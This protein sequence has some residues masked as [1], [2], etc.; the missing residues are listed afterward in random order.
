MK[1]FTWLFLLLSFSLSLFAQSAKNLSLVA[2]VPFPVDLNDVWAYVDGN[3]NEYA[4][5]G[6]VDGVS[7]FDLTDPSTPVEV[8]SIPGTLSVWRDL[9]IFQD[10]AYVSNDDA[11]GLLI[12][13]LSTLP[14]AVNYKDT[15][16]DGIDHAHNIY[17]EDGHLY[18]VGVGNSAMPTGFNGGMVIYDLRNDPWDPQF[19]GAYTDRYVHDVYVRGNR[20]YNGEIDDG[21]LTILD[22]TNKAN[23]SVLGFTDYPDSYTHNTWLNDAG[24]VCFTTDELKEAYVYAWDVTDPTSITLLDGIRSSLSEGLATPH[25]VHV[26]N[27]FLITSYYKDGIQLVD[28]TR[29]T[30]LVEVGHYDTSPMEGGGTDGCWGAYPFLPSGLVLA[31]DIQEGFFVLQPTYI[32]AA[33][34]EG[35]VTDLSNSAP[36]VNVLIEA[37]KP[38]L[39]DKT[40]NMGNYAVGTVDAGTYDIRYA[41]YGYMPENRTVSLSSG[42][43]TIEDVELQPSTPIDLT[44]KV[45]DA[46]TEDPIPFAQLV[47]IAPN[48]EASFPFLTDANGEATDSDFLTGLYEVIAGKWGHVTDGKEVVV[49]QANKTITI[50]LNAGYYDDFIFDN[51]WIKSGTANEGQWERGEP[52][53]TSF[54]GNVINPESDIEGDFGTYAYVTGNSGTGIGD[55]DV[56]GGTA[57]LTSP[58]MDLSNYEDPVLTFEWWLFNVDFSAPGPGNDY[59]RVEVGDGTNVVQVAEYT[60]SWANIWKPQPII[61]LKDHFP[62]LS[63][64]MRVIFTTADDAPGNIVEA[65]IDAFTVIEHS[66]Y[67]TG[68]DVEE[69][70]NV[71]FSIFPQPIQEEINVRYDV[72]AF[73]GKGQLTFELYD[74]LGTRLSSTILTGYNGEISLDFPLPKGLYVGALKLG[75][76]VIASRKVVK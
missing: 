16:M 59:L 70:T 23:P 19:V 18:M 22:L 4:L 31:T 74:L 33:Y 47:L 39:N 7:I 27:D 35:T 72:G 29:P 75:G 40:Q 24:N 21:L 60:N 76:K 71:T 49:D 46:A 11:G 8:A 25:N 51:P 55:D 1:K 37:I 45:V 50:E 57:I 69:V 3:G 12:I 66:L 67:S 62:T 43:V 2:H 20:A 48:N 34:L 6:R 54:R 15:V 56:D 36:L 65:A 68:I 9:K 61:H 41:K 5:V 52:L 64:Q 26:L 58:N 32:R 38:E 10:H 28:A 42:Q 53:G 17:I 30:N 73:Q 44:I 14:N 63:S 13:D